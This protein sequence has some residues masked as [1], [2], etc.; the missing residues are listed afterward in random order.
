MNVIAP[1]AHIAMVC[2]ASFG[3]A[4]QQGTS[5]AV[6]PGMAERATKG[7]ALRYGNR[8]HH[9]IAGLSESLQEQRH[10]RDRCEEDAGVGKS[11]G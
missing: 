10:D 1:H 9:C 2:F 11:R 7:K 6:K 8:A 3:N 4:K 5:A